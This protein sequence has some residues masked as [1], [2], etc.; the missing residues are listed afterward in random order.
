MAQEKSVFTEC[1]LR[2]L[3]ADPEL[4]RPEAQLCCVVFLL[5]QK[6][7]GVHVVVRVQLAEVGWLFPACRPGGL[8]SGLWA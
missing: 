1:G 7:V 4:L 2:C 3:P 5:M 6:G 8:N